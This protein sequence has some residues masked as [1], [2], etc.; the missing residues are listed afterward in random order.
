MY[1]LW[2]TS[3]D[4]DVDSLCR[5][6]LFKFGCQTGLTVADCKTHEWVCKINHIEVLGS[7][8]FWNNQ[9]SIKFR[10]EMCAG[11]SWY[12]DIKY[13]CMWSLYRS[14]LYSIQNVWVHLNKM[15]TCDFMIKRFAPVHSDLSSV[16]IYGT[17]EI[18]VSQGRWV[19]LLCSATRTSLSINKHTLSFSHTHKHIHNL[20]VITCTLSL[21]Y[22]L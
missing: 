22:T 3:K 15:D 11:V 2:P 7:C 14:I 19:L 18:V 5:N 1:T 10:M 16:T 17:P 6:D 21:T 8:G 12:L 20:S 13:T 4:T 9:N